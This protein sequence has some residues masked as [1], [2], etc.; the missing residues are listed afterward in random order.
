MKSLVVAPFVAAVV[1]ACGSSTTTTIV[2]GQPDAAGEKTNIVDDAGAEA[3]VVVTNS[4]CTAARQQALTPIAS[5]STGN[6]S[7]V[8]SS[9][10]PLEIYVDATAGGINAA[11]TH[12]RTY[13]KLDGTKAAI[14]DNDAFSSTGWDLALKRTDIYTNSGDAGPGQ[15]GAVA[16]EKDF[17]A[18]TSADAQHLAPEQ[19]FDSSCAEIKDEAGFLN[20]TFE[21]WYDYDTTT[22][23]PSAKPGLTFVVK[24][25]AGDLYKLQ[26]VSN[27]GTAAGGTNAT[28]TA[29]Y[30]LKVKKL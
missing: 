9:T 23:I 22:N 14:N 25:A 12:P 17:D 27:T 29:N 1:I 7:V 6:V 24:S 11:A 3:A 4:Q 10:D 18:V 21:G 26:I 28:A 16:V 8:G 13:I 5:V 2:E 30:L 19:F 15:G 20:T